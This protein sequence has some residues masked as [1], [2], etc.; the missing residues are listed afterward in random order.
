[1]KLLIGSAS[2]I[3]I[4]ASAFWAV[5]ST[6]SNKGTLGAT[7]LNAPGDHPSISHE[8]EPGFADVAQLVQFAQQ[9]ETKSREELKFEALAKMRAD[10]L[11]RRPVSLP[12]G[13]P[14][15]PFDVPL[16]EPKNDHHWPALADPEIQA[17]LDAHKDSWVVLNFW[18][19]WCAPCIHELPD[20]N[21]ASEPLDDIGVSLIAL[22]VDPMRKDTP[23]S[24]KAFLADKGIDRLTNATVTDDDVHNAMAAGGMKI[25]G[26]FS[27]PHN[28]VFAPGGVPYGYFQSLPMPLDNSPVWNSD[29]MIDFFTA[30]LADEPA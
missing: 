29:E 18:A 2:C 21:N 12:D 20:M 11:D 28:I 4:G 26:A 10:A 13:V 14:D 7:A 30:L 22:N 24:I 19:T 1:M 15:F 9:E 6:D 17:T 25:P 5:S 23:D 16:Y 27:Y 3:I 8:M